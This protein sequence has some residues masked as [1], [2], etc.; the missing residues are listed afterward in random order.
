M[1]TLLQEEGRPYGRPSA[2]IPAIVLGAVAGILLG[3]SEPLYLVVSLLA[4][5]GGVAAGFEHLGAAA[6]AIR[7]LIGG[8]LY[9]AA[10]LIAHQIEGS[11]AKANLPDPQILLVV[12]T[13]IIG[14]ALGALGGWLRARRA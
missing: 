6:G 14:A 8:G 7:G 2:V 4:A 12:L 3:V 10:L 13:V 9:G 11:A 5:A 1:I